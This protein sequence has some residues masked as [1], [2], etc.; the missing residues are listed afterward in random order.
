MAARIFIDRGKITT[1]CQRHRI[2][3]LALFGSVLRD[4][5]R[6][7]S[8][9]DVL[10]EFEPGHAVGLIRLAG[11]ELELSELLGRKVDLRTPADLSRYFR[12]EVLESAEVQYAQG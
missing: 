2:R 11:M 10:V 4:D 7:D 3:K 8:D 5:F 12:Q 9:V 1:F 6:P